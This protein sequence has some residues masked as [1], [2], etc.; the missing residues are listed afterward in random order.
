VE[1]S[2][3]WEAGLSIGKI[4]T[5][6]PARWSVRTNPFQPPWQDLGAHKDVS[7]DMVV[8]IA[9]VPLET[10]MIRSE[11]ASQ[12]GHGNMGRIID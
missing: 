10:M 8:L 3:A 11:G 9:R 12:N 1:P 7:G 2:N 6:K 4:V 5:K